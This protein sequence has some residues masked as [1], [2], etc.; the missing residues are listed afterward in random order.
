LKS[1]LAGARK[2]AG[3]EKAGLKEQGEATAW[4][5]LIILSA[6]GKRS[7]L[8]ASLP[9]LP[10]RKRRRASL[11]GSFRIQGHAGIGKWD[12]IDLFIRHKISIF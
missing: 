3:K 10:S 9:A 6:E 7:R 4:P 2:R 8:F 11:S 12:G 1:S 5:P